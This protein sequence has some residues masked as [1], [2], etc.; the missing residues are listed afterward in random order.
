[1]RYK[2]NIKTKIKFSCFWSIVK[3]LKI[4][5]QYL[6]NPNKIKPYK[7]VFSLKNFS[8]LIHILQNFDM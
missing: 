3:L 5:T 4:Y 1:M 2:N 6:H 8:R 7:D